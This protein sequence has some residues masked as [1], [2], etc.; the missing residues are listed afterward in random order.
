MIVGIGVDLLHI[1]RLRALVQRRSTQQLARRIL[2]P[3]ELAEWHDRGLD[4]S[5]E[6]AEKY[7]ALRW[8]AK[9]A[10]YKAL[11]PRIQATWK[12]LVVTKV[13]RKPCLDFSNTLVE[14]SNLQAQRDRD[15]LKLHLSVSHD[16]GFMTAYVVAEAM[17]STT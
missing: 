6:A 8:T 17:A 12:D 3:E 16:G 5:Q 1:A 14:R 4:D 9:E 13:D 2:A 7:L 11:Y 10:A 15:R